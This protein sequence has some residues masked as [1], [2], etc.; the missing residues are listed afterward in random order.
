[1]ATIEIG[2]DAFDVEIL[3]GQTTPSTFSLHVEY[4]T[5][6]RPGRAV[7]D[8][9]VDERSDLTVGTIERTLQEWADANDGKHVTSFEFVEEAP[10]RRG[11]RVE[12]L[13]E[14]G[15]P[16]DREAG[17]STDS[18]SARDR[19]PPLGSTTIRSVP[20]ADPVDGTEGYERGDHVV[21]RVG[22]TES[23]VYSHTTDGIVAAVPPYRRGQT[24]DVVRESFLLD[25]GERRLKQVPLDRIVGHV[26]DDDV[27][28]DNPRS[29]EATH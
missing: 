13:A 12:P 18:P 17:A 9:D 16:T 4:R 26:T 11:E 24:S 22:D 20:G 23:G 14:P 3:S 8:L 19:R 7:V 21:Y 5:G 1:M 10:A 29:L 2:G 25:V 15:A 28:V 27:T 6:S